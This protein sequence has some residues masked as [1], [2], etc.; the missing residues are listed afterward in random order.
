[1]KLTTFFSVRFILLTSMFDSFL[2][3]CL[4]L[5]L[6]GMVQGYHTLVKWTGTDRHHHFLE[7]KF[8]G[9]SARYMSVIDTVLLTQYSKERKTRYTTVYFFFTLLLRRFNYGHVNIC[10]TV[11]ILFY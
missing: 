7:L 10:S 3:F 1:M 4:A 2:V 11:N 5:G 8:H 9:R 6:I